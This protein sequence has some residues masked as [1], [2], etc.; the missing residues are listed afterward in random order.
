MP[1][2]VVYICILIVYIN[3]RMFL[4]C[5]VWML[6]VLVVCLFICFVYYVYVNL[7]RVRYCSTSRWTPAER[8]PSTAPY[9]TSSCSRAI[10][11]AS[12]TPHCPSLSQCP[13]SWSWSLQTCRTVSGLHARVHRVKHFRSGWYRMLT[14]WRWDSETY[15]QHTRTRTHTHVCTHLSLLPVLPSPFSLSLSCLPFSW[16]SPTEI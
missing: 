2:P 11:P 13:P 1:L 8:S 15:G 5:Q 12:R 10:W 3:M 7:H 14:L 6:V 16:S 9:R 4:V